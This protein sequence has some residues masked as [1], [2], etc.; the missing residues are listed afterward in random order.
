[1]SETV[2]KSA[3][4]RFVFNELTMNA[5]I[6]LMTPRAFRQFENAID[7]TV[8]DMSKELRK[9]GV[10]IINDERKNHAQ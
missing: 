8:R 7:K 9:R 5:N 1:M 6:A 4:R 2:L 3:L 10:T